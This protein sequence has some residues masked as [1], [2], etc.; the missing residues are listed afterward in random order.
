MKPNHCSRN[1]ENQP[2]N[3]KERGRRGRRRGREGKKKK[4][5]DKKKKKEE[6]EEVRKIR[7]MY[8]DDESIKVT[9]S[10]NAFLFSFS[11]PIE[12]RS[13]ICCLGPTQ[14]LRDAELRAASP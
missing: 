14:L 11:Y 3:L 8:G 2:V 5:Q 13:I 9:Q 6:E 7:H 12:L 1:I 10:D 4:K